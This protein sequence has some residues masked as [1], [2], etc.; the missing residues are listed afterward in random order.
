MKPATILFLVA[1]TLAPAC[2]SSR[3][4]PQVDGLLGS[5]WLAARAQQELG[6]EA[7][8]F[9][10]AAAVVR[11]DPEHAGAARLMAGFES[12]NEQLFDHPFLGSNFKQRPEVNRSMAARVL[13]YLPDRLLDMA[14][15]F[16]FD[17]H[18]GLGAYA[19]VHFTRAAQAGGGF[20]AVGGFGWHDQRSLG[21]QSQSI[22]GVSALGMGTQAFGASMVGT[23]GVFSTGDAMVGLHRPSME[24]YQDYLDY[25]AVGA[26][27]TAG[28]VGVDFDF[29]PIELVD[30][31]LGFTTLDILN[32]DFGRT[33]GLRLTRD[34]R[35]L[36]I[37]LGE[38]ESRPDEVSA[39]HDWVAA[40]RASGPTDAQPAS[41]PARGA[42]SVATSED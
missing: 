17:V 21:L 14:D 9:Q 33:R 2:A 35:S 42:A 34:E 28:I 4:G 32:D 31:L 19:N 38:V 27:V 18:F 26:S 7:E 30:A 24:I 11:V 41:L 3:S 29:H 25:W 10:L 37:A 20:R 5:A 8:S 40:G 15:V 6:N 12:D 39:Y 36:L 22:V 13:L 16:S 1:I 23:S